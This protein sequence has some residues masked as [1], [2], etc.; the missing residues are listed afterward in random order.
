MKNISKLI[1]A[2]TV[3]LSVSTISFARNAAPGDDPNDKKDQ[4][5]SGTWVTGAVPPTGGCAKCEERK[6][7]LSDKKDNFQ[8]GMAPSGTKDTSGDGQSNK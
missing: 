5:S 1:F 3:V 2:I 7:L 6:L 4:S 8:P